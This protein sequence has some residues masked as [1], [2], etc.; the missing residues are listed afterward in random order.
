LR[1][2]RRLIITRRLAVLLAFCG[3]FAVSR[4]AAVQAREQSVSA[5]RLS[6]VGDIALST[7][8][9]L[10]PG[11][12]TGALAAVRRQLAWADVGT[13]N[14][15]GTLSTG[16]AA[17][18]GAQI[19]GPDC[20]SF[21]APTGYARELRTLGFT[22][23]NQANNHSNDFG[24]AGRAQTVAAL[25]GAGVGHT[26]YTDEISYLRVKGIR[27]AFLGFAPFS[28]DA[29]LRDIPAAGALVRRA[30]AHARLVVVFMH[31]G[32]E[33]ADQLHTPDHS[34]S[35]L[36][37][38][39]GNPQ[40]FAHAMVR[41]GAAVVLGSGPHVIR[42]VE[43][44]RGHLIAYSAG[45]FEGDHTLAGGGVLDDSTI[46]QLELSPGGELL[47]ADWVPITLT[48]GL[49]RYDPTGAS[50]RLVAR[51]SAEDFPHDHF[52]I[53]PNGTFALPLRWEAAPN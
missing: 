7:Q 2:S 3:V 11:G 42:G 45:N 52:R 10:P 14:L 36:G 49:P 24:P 20:Y 16:G 32:A 27:I 21:Q 22:M 43:D 37:E 34:E 40:A 51:L 46:L 35:F 28:G 17:K 25:A 50:A 41:A 4:P 1:L 8:L 13:G 48:D 9:G 33:G 31:D 44:Y 29:D 53:R 6:W 5:I 19:T 26:G 39:R 47:A 15:E 38:D 30:R 12:L 18:C 23:V